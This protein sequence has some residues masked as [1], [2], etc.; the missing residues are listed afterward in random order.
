MRIL[1]GVSVFV[2]LAGAVPA[3]PAQDYPNRPVRLVAPFSPGGGTDALARIMAQKLNQRWGHTVVVDNRPGAG[4]TIGADHV[5]KSAPDGYTLMV[6]GVPHAIAVSIYP[7]LPY[8]MARDLAAISGVATFPSMIVLHPSLPVRSVKELVALAKAR[9]GQ[10][11]F[12]S[13]GLGSPNRLAMELFKT[14]T[15]VSMVHIGYTTNGQLMAELVTGQLHLASLGFPVAMP[16][17][18][19]GKLHVIAVT[20]AARSAFLPDVPSVAEAGVPGFELNSWYGIFGPAATPRDI[21]ARLNSETAAVLGA[22]DVKE[23]LAALGAEPAPMSPD[24]FARLTR[25]EIV[26]WAKV[27]KQSGARAE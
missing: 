23:R 1:A 14:M 19:A 3:V 5:A 27:V 6:G 22:L 17:V 25:E 7:K 24:D 26:K 4:G 15:Q 21:I 2:M 20:S 11:N 16:M 13:V 10:L 12:G 9:P 8:D 18:K